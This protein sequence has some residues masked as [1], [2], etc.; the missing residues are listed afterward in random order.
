MVARLDSRSAAT[1][2]G[3]LVE[4]RRPLIGITGRKDTSAR[5][6][7]APM[8]SVGVTYTRAV[9][10]AGGTPVI[11]PPLTR[12]VDWPPLLEQLDGL[13]LSGGEDI[14]PAYYGQETEP[15]TGRVDE[16]RDQSEIGLVRIWLATG[17]PL[18]AICRGHQV[19][20]V[21]LGGSLI[22]DIMAQ[23]PNALDH[24]TVPGRP[25]EQVVHTVE[26]EL[27]S[28][29]SEILGDTELAVNSAHHQAVALPG[30]GLS[31]I[32]HA[33]DGVLEATEL[34]NHPFCVTVQWHPEAMLRT[35]RTMLPLFTAFVVAAVKRL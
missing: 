5:L 8:H 14:A 12:D 10:L 26:I 32:A 7:N 17:K 35:S 33:P 31:P 27:G 15:W 19:L 28:R 6:L 30:K 9:H 16:E 1:R 29:L 20:N 34:P 4:Q 22:Q 13:L 24:A 23:V 21:A 2:S 3:S 11:V 18:L 25:M